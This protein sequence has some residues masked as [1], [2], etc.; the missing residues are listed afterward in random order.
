ML[1]PLTHRK[2]LKEG[3]PGQA[4]IVAIGALDRNSTTFN[5]PM[6]LQVYVE[7][8]TPYEVEGQWWVKAKD[9]SGLSG[10][11][12]VKVDREDPQKVAI[13]WE[14]VRRKEEAETRARQEALAAH[15]PWQG[16]APGMPANV[17]IHGDLDPA[18]LAALGGMLGG[19]AGAGGAATGEPQ[20][21]AMTPSI[22]LRG[23]PELRAKIEALLG[24]KLEP[25]STARVAENDP[26]LQARIMQV[27][28]E[29]VASKS[30]G[31]A[32][33]APGF[34]A[35]G[36]AAAAAD[37]ADAAD[38]RLDQLERLAELRDRGVITEAEFQQQK[39]EILGRG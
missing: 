32:G 16:G 14:G 21:Q 6:T 27:V 35:P 31:G 25:G 20:V 8:R 9:A 18:Q 24:R 37:P 2:V 4:T 17:A 10:T 29:H 22:D 7:G 5:L 1:N 30:G 15:G 19:L 38:E 34:G 11:I 26:E 39:A 12:P 36:F 13:D 28:A 33:G 23:D 3:I